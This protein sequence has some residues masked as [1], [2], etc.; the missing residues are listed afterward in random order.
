M[1]AAK[2][3]FF[4]SLSLP[5]AKGSTWQ[6]EAKPV[7]E[8]T[9]IFCESHATEYVPSIRH[10]VSDLAKLNLRATTEST[11][12][13]DNSVILRSF[14]VKT[15]RQDFN[16]ILPSACDSAGLLKRTTT[17]GVGTSGNVA[18]DFRSDFEKSSFLARMP[19]W[20]TRHEHIVFK[21]R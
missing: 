4:R 7:A 6:P 21:T 1:V 8:L 14:H 19:T 17:F 11:P 12:L 9:G 5:Q 3:L 20:G 2:F 18:V 13:P 10:V 16:L 15:L